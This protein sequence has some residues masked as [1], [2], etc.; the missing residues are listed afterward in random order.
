MKR[1]YVQQIT[2]EEMI[3][4][5]EFF[6][7][8]RLSLGLNL[9]QMAEKVGIFRT[10][11]SKWEKGSIIPNEDIYTVEQKFRS[12]ANSILKRSKDKWTN[13]FYLFSM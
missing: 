2:R 6:K 11:L 1:K 13:R 3:E 4:Y 10:T 5:G 7:N 12:V 8:I 9:E